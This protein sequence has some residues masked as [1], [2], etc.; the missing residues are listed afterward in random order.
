MKEKNINYTHLFDK[1]AF[2]KLLAEMYD[3]I[4]ECNNET[5][6]ILLTDLFNK[7]GDCIKTAYKIGYRQAILNIGLNLK[8]FCKNE[9]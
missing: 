8:H 6:K 5:C 7:I 4:E 2:Q 9:G 3:E 1:E